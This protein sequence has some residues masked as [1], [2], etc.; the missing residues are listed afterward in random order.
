VHKAFSV[1]TLA[2]VLCFSTFSLIAC[3][4]ALQITQQRIEVNEFTI[5]PAQSYAAVS[6][7][8]EN[9]GWFAAGNVLVAVNF[10]DS[11]GN[12][13]GAS[14]AM[15]ER[16]EAGQVWDFKVVMRG[17]DAWKVARYELSASSH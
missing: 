3:Q 5:D 15:K 14:S 11:Q 12:K 8:L 2:L 16:L 9:R 13:V 1:I 4:S 6:G 10:Y 7:V 17:E